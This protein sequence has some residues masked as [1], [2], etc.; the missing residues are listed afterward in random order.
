MIVYLF[1]NAKLITLG[2]LHFNHSFLIGIFLWMPLVLY[3]QINLSIEKI[4]SDNITS[5]KVH[6]TNS[7]SEDVWF[8]Y[9]NKSMADNYSRIIFRYY[10]E[11]QCI[12]TFEG[13]YRTKE[14]TTNYRIDHFKLK[15][16]ATEEFIYDI[17]KIH[18]F[19]SGLKATKIE[20]SCF[21]YAIGDSTGKYYT[22]KKE[23]EFSLP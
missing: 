11:N 4:K 17:D 20:I 6:I 15:K 2:R 5:I 14:M 23:L 9:R 21:I 19:V 16:G 13:I 3:A 1:P 22:N 8:W 7:S 18:T 10:F 12:G